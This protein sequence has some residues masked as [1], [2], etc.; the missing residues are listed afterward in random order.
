MVS[1]FILIYN[2]FGINLIRWHEEL[3]SHKWFFNYFSTVYSIILSSWTSL[4]KSDLSRCNSYSYDSVLNVT[5]AMCSHN[6]QHTQMEY[7]H[8]PPKV[9]LCPFVVNP[10][11]PT[12]QPLA[13]LI[14]SLWSCGFAFSWMSMKYTTYRLLSS[15]FSLTEVLLTFV[16]AVVCY[17][18]FI[19]LIDE[20]YSIV[21]THH[22][23]QT[24]SSTIKYDGSHRVFVDV[25]YQIEKALVCWVFIINGCSILSNAFH[26]AI[27]EH[28]LVL[29]P[30]E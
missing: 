9:C 6:N 4:L 25:Y 18:Q 20:E 27:K 14:C 1:F 8:H 17:Q 16:H 29:L 2:P 21:G 10:P 7:F 5:N 12:C 11:F 24:L 19:H 30:W 3:T 23:S 13:T 28:I 22:N 15:A 26:A